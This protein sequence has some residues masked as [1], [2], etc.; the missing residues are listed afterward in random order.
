MPDH[1]VASA[2]STIHCSEIPFVIAGLSCISRLARI[3]NCRSSL[4]AT[5]RLPRCRRILCAVCHCEN[6]F[7]DPP[8]AWL[9]REIMLTAPVV[10]YILGRDLSFLMRPSQMPHPLDVLSRWPTLSMRDAVQRLTVRGVRI[11]WTR[12]NGHLSPHTR[13]MS[14]DDLHRPLS[15]ICVE[16]RAFETR[17]S[18]VTNPDS[19]SVSWGCDLYAVLNVHAQAGIDVAASSPSLR[20]AQ[21][22]A[23]RVSVREPFGRELF[24]LAQNPKSSAANRGSSIRSRY[25]DPGVPRRGLGSVAGP[26]RH[27]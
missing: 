21:P 11:G 22:M 2:T 23:P 10:E 9:S 6:D 27:R 8:I 18:S 20:G 4:F 15:V 1:E 26:V 14:V 17:L 13:M 19:L 16:W 25:H 24:P 7:T 5:C 3:R 12:D